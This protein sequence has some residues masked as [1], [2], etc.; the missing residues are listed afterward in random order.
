MRF[1]VDTQ[2]P[3]ALARLLSGRG[4]IAEHVLDLKMGQSSDRVIWDYANS[5]DAII[6]T[7][8]QDFANRRAAVRTGP[9]I[10]WLRCG[11]TRRHELLVWFEQ[12]FSAILAAIERG[13]TLIEIR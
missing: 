12:S 5:C 9:V 7:K 6:V 3:T 4:Y 2:L 8:D 10:V 1:V 11:N 13:E